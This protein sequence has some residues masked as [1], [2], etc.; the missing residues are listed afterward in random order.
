[1][2]VARDPVLGSY[3][4]VALLAFWRVLLSRFLRHR[5]PLWYTKFFGFVLFSVYSGPRYPK[6]ISWPRY[7]ISLLEKGSLC[8]FSLNCHRVVS[9]AH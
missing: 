5:H 4:D 2:W 6:V 1:M 3:D 7:L 8:L 9:S